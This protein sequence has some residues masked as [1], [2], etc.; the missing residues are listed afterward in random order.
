M[1]ELRVIHRRSELEKR[2]L[3]KTGVKAALI[4][5]L[6]KALRDAGEDIDTFEFVVQAE[7]MPLQPA[8]PTSGKPLTKRVKRLPTTTRRLRVMKTR[9]RPRPVRAGKRMK[10]IRMIQQ[11]ATIQEVAELVDGTTDLSSVWEAMVV[12]QAGLRDIRRTEMELNT[13]G[14]AFRYKLME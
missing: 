10:V 9:T 12:I 4:E 8:T 3:D 5:Q 1:P 11:V 6:G 2:G 7:L 13:L 14:Q